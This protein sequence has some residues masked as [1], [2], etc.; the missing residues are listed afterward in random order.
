[1]KR[2]LAI[3]SFSRASAWFRKGAGVLIAGLGI[4]FL[5]RPFM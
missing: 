1:V 3:S 5:A 4:Y 2:L